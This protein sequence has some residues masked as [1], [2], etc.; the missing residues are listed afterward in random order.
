MAMAF[1]CAVAPLTNLNTLPCVNMQDYQARSVFATEVTIHFSPFPA[2]AT[3]KKGVFHATQGTEYPYKK[4]KKA[5]TAAFLCVVVV[6]Q[7]L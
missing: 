2:L 4:H 5:T 7:T 6:G 1:Y 3:H